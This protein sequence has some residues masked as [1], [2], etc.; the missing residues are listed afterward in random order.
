[1]T[2]QFMLSDYDCKGELHCGIQ[3]ELEG[4]RNAYDAM[5][6]HDC[7]VLVIDHEGHRFKTRAY[8]NEFGNKVFDAT[9][10]KGFDI[11]WWKEV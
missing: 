4:Y 2:R 3:Y 7:E 11:C 10:S 1:M 9:K 6:D 8:R 5:P